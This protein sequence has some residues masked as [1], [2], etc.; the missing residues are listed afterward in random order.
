MT[1]RGYDCGE[2]NNSSQRSLNPI[3]IGP[4]QFLGITMGRIQDLFARL[5]WIQ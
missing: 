1:G 4:V 5:S 3:R 2:T